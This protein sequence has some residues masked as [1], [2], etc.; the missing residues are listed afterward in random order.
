MQTSEQRKPSI[1]KPYGDVQD[2]L[3]PMSVPLVLDL[4]GE[5]LRT[6]IVSECLVSAIKRSPIVLLLAIW[7]MIQGRA[8]L[9]QRLAAR[10]GIEARLLPINEGV[11]SYAAEQAAYGRAVVIVTAANDVLARRAAKRFPF[12]SRLI[13]LD[14]VAAVRQRKGERLREM[15]P[16]GFICLADL[17]AGAS[18]EPREYLKAVRLNQWCKNLLV[19]APMALSGKL[20]HLDAWLPALLAFLA[21]SLTASATYLINDLCDLSDDRNHWSKRDRPLAKGTMPIGHGFA[22]SLLLLVTGLCMAAALG[23]G[24][25][26]ALSAYLILSLSYTF[27]LKTMPIVDVTALASLFTMR[28]E[29]GVLAVSAPLS[30]WLFVF[31]MALFLSL[32]LAKRH[33]E[34]IR[35]SLH[36]AKTMSG[37]GYIARDEPLLLALG[38]AAAASSI[39]LLS[40]YLTG[41]VFSAGLYARP[42]FLWAAP[43]LLFLWLGRIWLLSQRGELDDDPVAFA[44]KDKLS[45]TLGAALIAAFCVASFGGP[46]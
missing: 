1:R 43:G 3:A 40:L 27:A 44:V 46:A 15:F 13:V 17:G 28:L 2:F 25:F 30:P 14:A 26:A 37:R 33:T 16:Q 21:L 10:G 11:A 38:T 20:F 45:L 18:A 24:V 42:G 19:L 7:W 32:S 29:I 8:V 23:L 41:Q 22:L 35:M 36:G 12:A 31:S 39:V 9:K 34:L 6:N 5:L 4:D